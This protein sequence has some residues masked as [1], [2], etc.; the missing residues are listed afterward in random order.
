MYLISYI[1]TKI[2]QKFI[3]RFI[4]KNVRLTESRWYGYEKTTRRQCGVYRQQKHVQEKDEK[5]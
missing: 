1:D 4:I 2:N 5:A 3:T